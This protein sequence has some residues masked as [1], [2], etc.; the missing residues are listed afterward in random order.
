VLEPP[1][2]MGRYEGEQRQRHQ[3]EQTDAREVEPADTALGPTVDRRPED[4]VQMLVPT[5][6]TVHGTQRH[7]QIGTDSSAIIKNQLRRRGDKQRGASECL[8]SACLASAYT[9]G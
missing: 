9:S 1:L 5:P 8:A 2:P 6:R 7:R 4:L 3:V